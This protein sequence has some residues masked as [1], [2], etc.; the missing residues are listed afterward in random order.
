MGTELP[1]PIKLALEYDIDVL[2]VGARTTVNPLQCKKQI[3]EPK[4]LYW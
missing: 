4:K 2:W 3:K 1:T